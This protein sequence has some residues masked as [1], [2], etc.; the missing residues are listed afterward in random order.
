MNILFFGTGVIGSI[1]AGK[2]SS[3]GQNVTVLDKEPRLSEIR[4]YGILLQ[5]GVTGEKTSA[6]VNTVEVLGPNDYYDLVVVPVRADHLPAILPVLAANMVIPNILIMVNNPKGSGQI[7]ELLGMERVLLG[8][9]GMGGGKHGSV[10][11]YDIAKP[12]VQPSTFGELDGRLTPR[13][14]EIVTMFKKA[15]FPVV[16]EK[17]MDAWQKTHVSWVSP[18]ADAIYMAGGDN[19]QLA[20]RPDVIRMMIEAIREAF[21]VLKKMSVPITPTKFKFINWLPIPLQ[22][23]VWRKV[24]AGRDIEMLATLHCQKAPQEMQQLAH[25]LIALARCT[26]IPTPSLNRL[27]EY[28]ATIKSGDGI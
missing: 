5:N 9:P 6:R 8:F 12:L 4:E 14:I 17:N 18:L 3:T 13:L 11:L 16:I 25:E 21:A 22:I 2:L 28:M 24:L 26:S 20:E 23:M 15:G 27:S 7:V 1:L 19:Y 10:I